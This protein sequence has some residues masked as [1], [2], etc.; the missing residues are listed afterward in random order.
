MDDIIHIR[1]LVAV[2]RSRVLL[3]CP[4]C[5]Q[6]HTEF[7]DKLRGSRFYACTGDGCDYRFDLL[8][9]PRSSML[10]G[11]AAAWRRFYAALIPTG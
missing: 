5:G 9:G 11:L 7:A 6:E 4:D 3:I 10:Q 8:E 2:A 1:Q